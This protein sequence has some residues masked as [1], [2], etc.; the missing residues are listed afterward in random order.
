MTETPGTS[1]GRRGVRPGAGILVG[2]LRPGRA[3]RLRVPRRLP[4]SRRGR[5]P[6]TFEYGGNAMT[7]RPGG[8]PAGG[9]DGFPGSLFVTGHDRMPYGELPD[10]SRVAEVGIP[11]PVV[12]RNVEEPSAGAP[13]PAA[14]RRH[15]RALRGNR[16]DPAPRDAVPRGPRPVPASISRGES[17][18]RRPRTAP[19]TPGSSPTCPRRGPGGPGSSMASPPTP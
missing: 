2:P 12:S 9:T 6:L 16:R 11:A 4:A 17:T 15:G 7:F 19:R 8:D 3:V 1:D 18:S 5:T 10:G 13:H 14:D